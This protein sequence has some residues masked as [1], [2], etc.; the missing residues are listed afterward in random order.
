MRY[1]NLH[2]HSLYI[3]DSRNYGPSDVG[4]Y[5]QNIEDFMCSSGQLKVAELGKLKMTGAGLSSA[6]F[7]LTSANTWHY[8]S[9]LSRSLAT[10]VNALVSVNGVALRWARPVVGWVTAFG[11][12]NHLAIPAT[13]ANSAWPPLWVGTSSIGDGYGYR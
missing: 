9:C 6:A 12:E 7:H 1:I 3:L 4:N 11:Q 10:S 13:H 8:A 2:S 5:V